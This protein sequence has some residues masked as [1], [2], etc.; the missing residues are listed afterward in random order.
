MTDVNISKFQHIQTLL[1][2]VIGMIPENERPE[3]TTDLMPTAKNI[4]IEIE[5]NAELYL[6][7]A[8]QSIAG[9]DYIR[10]LFLL[11]KAIELL[12]ENAWEV[13]DLAIRIYADM[14]NV[15]R[16]TT[17]PYRMIE[18]AEIALKNADENPQ[19]I[20]ITELKVDALKSLNRLDEAFDEL[21]NLFKRIRFELETA[22]P[23]IRDL[24]RLVD[25]FSDLPEA[26]TEWQRS[27]LRCVK[28]FG[29]I[30]YINHLELIPSVAYSEVS[31][32]LQYG[33][34]P[35]ALSALIDY[36][37]LLAISGNLDRGYQLGET[38]VR[39]LESEGNSLSKPSV[40]HIFYGLIAPW[41]ENIN[42]SIEILE[43]AWRAGIEVGDLMIASVAAVARLDH[44][45]MIGVPLSYLKKE[46][47]KYL[48]AFEQFNLEYPI[49][50]VHLYLQVIA[51][52]QGE[53][54]EATTLTGRIFNEVEIDEL[55]RQNPT[56]AYLFYLAKIMFMYWHG[57]PQKASQYFAA[58]QKC[59]ASALGLAI[60]AELKFY[61]V[62][63]QIATYS[64]THAEDDQIEADLTQIQQWA[65]NAPDNF[66]H[67]YS[68]ANA[69]WLKSKRRYEEAKY[70]YARAIAFAEEQG[71]IQDAALANELA[72]KFYLQQGQHKIAETH[73]I[74][75]HAGF[76]DWGATAVAQRMEREYDCLKDFDLNTDFAQAICNRIETG[77]SEDVRKILSRFAVLTYNPATQQVELLVKTKVA[78]AILAPHLESLQRHS[79]VKIVL[80]ISS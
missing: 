19:K 30:C 40:L 80:K 25:R 73:L 68:L 37:F 26:S 24:D 45:F 39:L 14:G 59:S 58:A 46:A 63:A 12:G 60:T 75:A 62:L 67:W 31:L 74:A 56:Q 1:S 66:T 79:L 44:L 22:P 20:L 15:Y 57:Q 77:C 34:S 70:H 4:P 72:G 32:V 41:K 51:N 23:T 18:I 8:K 13:Q 69:E 27:L 54:Y 47:L 36:A 29:E 61:R 6:A 78:A 35:L 71:R 48:N 17:D 16:L 76:L 53:T 55:E 21:T 3:W 49:P 2:T 52:L 9:K 50:Y 65:D 28:H 11:S 43:L 64:G 42:D 7:A 33:K 10:A 5:A 38:I